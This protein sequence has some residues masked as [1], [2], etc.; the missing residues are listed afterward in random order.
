ME[1]SVIHSIRFRRPEQ[2]YVLAKMSVPSEADAATQVR[3][4]EDLGYK[5]VD[6]SPPLSEYGPPQSPLLP[7]APLFA[8][9]ETASSPKCD[10]QR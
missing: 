6:V 2:L 10:T 5:V 9:G 7:S 8:V 4:L 1:Q 3:H